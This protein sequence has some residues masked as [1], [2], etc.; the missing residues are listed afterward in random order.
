MTIQYARG[1]IGE[2][3]GKLD[4][5]DRPAQ[6]RLSANSMVRHSFLA[7]RKPYNP[8][9]SKDQARGGKSRRVQPLIK[10]SLSFT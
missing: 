8:S 10:R 6:S 3:S 1:A 7:A 2:R 9:L 5:N 4:G